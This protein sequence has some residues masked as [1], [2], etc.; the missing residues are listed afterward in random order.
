MLKLFAFFLLVIGIAAGGGWAVSRSS[1]DG[2]A[3]AA[4]E[5]AGVFLNVTIKE[6]VEW[7]YA[8]KWRDEEARK[9]FLKK[10]DGASAKLGEILQ[11]QQRIRS[12]IENSSAEDWDARYGQSGIWDALGADLFNTTC[13]KGQVDYYRAGALEKMPG[14]RAANGVLDI[15]AKLP[16]SA[17]DEPWA[18]LMRA[19]AYSIL[20]KWEADN[21]KLAIELFKK[22]TS[23]QGLAAEVYFPAVIG[24]YGVEVPSAAVIEGLSERMAASTLCDDLEANLMLGVL[25]KRAGSGAIMEKAASRWPQAKVIAGEIAI[26]DIIDG[27]S[28]SQFDSQVGAEAALAKG[29]QYCRY[30]VALAGDKQFASGAVLA[31]AAAAIEANEPWQAGQYYLKAA[32]TGTAAAKEQRAN[33][34]K[35]AA[36]IGYNISEDGAGCNLARQAFEEYFKYEPSGTAGAMEFS[37]AQVLGKCGWRDEAAKKLTAIAADASSP[38]R[39]HAKYT[40]LEESLSKAGS[41]DAKYKIAG[42]LVLLADDKDVSTEV[43]TAAGVLY[44]G[45]MLATGEP[46][47]A[48]AVLNFVDGGGSFVPKP[49]AMMYKAQAKLI[50]GRTVESGEDLTGL[51][52]ELCRARATGIEVVSEYVENIDKHL[53]ATRDPAKELAMM[54]A[55]TAGLKSCEGKKDARLAAAFYTLAAMKAQADVN[56]LIAK[57]QTDMKEFGQ[58]WGL[59]AAMGRLEMAA[60]DWDKA[61]VSWARCS[62]GVKGGTERW[63]TAKY[64]EYFSLSRKAGVNN[65][66]LVHSMEVTQN[67]YK[68][69]PAIW[70]VK[71]DDLRKQLNSKF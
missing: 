55:L 41:N 35:K 53:A 3:R 52:G 50:L 56:D 19:K 45:S 71:F 65:T 8:Q 27:K 68:G 62:C 39:W 48:A 17:Q 37:Y 34:A 69:G 44:C 6:R 60:N 10:A 12:E 40:L 38:F 5:E 14:I 42:E 9:E 23:Q 1:L 57:C 29:P 22:I 63:W 28:V 66:E 51:A 31:A 15:F 21:K 20:G 4:Q 43:R 11:N 70:Q 13:L 64:Y 32:Q 61:A 67:S 47:A 18:I 30:F 25:A 54:E 24:L 59:M 7:E 49:D 58:D 16:K 33:W 2:L 46:D 36:V 26:C